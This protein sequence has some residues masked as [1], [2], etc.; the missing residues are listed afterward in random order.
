MTKKSGGQRT[1]QTGAGYDLAA[2]QE[3]NAVGRRLAALREARGLS[4]AELSRQLE[5]YGIRLG[6]STI[7]KWETGVSSPNAYQLLALC[8]F[9]RV[10]AADYFTLT[11]PAS[12]LNPAGLKKLD[13]YRE[14]LIASGRYRAEPITVITGIRYRKMP[15]SRIPVSA[16]PGAWLDDDA[17]EE[18][19]F[20]ED[21]VPGGAEFG[22]RISGRSMEPV[23]HQDQIVWVQRCDSLRPGEVGI[24]VY[25]GEGY[26]KVYDEREPEDPESFTDSAGA[27]HRQPVMVS[28]NPDYPPRV[29]SPHLE[30]MICGRVL[31]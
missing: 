14:D 31:R 25:D 27:L 22:L 6:R 28:Y 10:S 30:F 8:R 26:I 19:A 16:G 20:P 3:N 4:L 13:S 17:F 29:I 1:P 11:P 23:Y 18:I 7:G 2:E 12:V 21:T 15:V 5:P 9:F 24:M